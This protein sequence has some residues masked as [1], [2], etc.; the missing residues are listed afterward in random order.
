MKVLV[1]ADMEGLAG[2]VQWDSSED[3]LVRR[4]M[5]EEVNAA[6]RG[7]FVGGATSVFAAQSHGNARNLLPEAL[8]P[9]IACIAGQPMPGN[10]MAGV[11]ASFDLALFVGYHSKA[12]TP[13]GVMAHTF[14]V[15]VFSLAV[16]GIEMGEIG[17]DAA[18]CGR[19]GVPVGLVCGDTAAC[20]EAVVQLGRVETVAV[21]EGLGRHTARCLPLGLARRRIA[22]AAE[23]AVRHHSDYA[24]FV[25]PGPVEVRLTFTAP[26][27]ADVIEG[28]GSVSRLDG[29]TVSFT[30]EDFATAFERLNA[31]HIP[32]S[33][34]C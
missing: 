18:L 2:L 1:A 22:E 30:G 32:A 28:L 21:K 23:V 29:C 7:A 11:D 5:T 10:H 15:H 26:G 9:R 25:I 27:Y 14:N 3:A 4:L 31:V 16:N 12:G 8:D 19:Y 20:A 24:P 34:V 33:L 13:H 6:A 17:I